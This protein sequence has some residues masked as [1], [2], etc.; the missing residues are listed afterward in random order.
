MGIL[1][2]PGCDAEL[3]YKKELVLAS[4]LSQDYFPLSQ[5]WFHVIYLGQLRS[6]QTQRLSIISI[7]QKVYFVDVASFPENK[8]IPLGRAC[9][10]APRIPSYLSRH[11]THFGGNLQWVAIVYRCCTLEL[12][13]MLAVVMQIRLGK[14]PILRENMR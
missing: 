3:K 10:H 1:Q 4:E 13:D 8:R 9:I 5:T 14:A 12:M 6:I 7:A 2:P 11:H